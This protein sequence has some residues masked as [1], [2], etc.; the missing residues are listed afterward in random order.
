MQ[1]IHSINNAQ[2]T[3]K[4]IPTNCQYYESIDTNY[5][6]ANLTIKHTK[7][8]LGPQRVPTSLRLQFLKDNKDNME[9]IQPNTQ[10]NQLPKLKR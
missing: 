6:K 4:I 10:T 7:L 2:S 5:T 3:T 8:S 1:F 9:E